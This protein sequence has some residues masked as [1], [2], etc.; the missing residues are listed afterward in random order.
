MGLFHSLQLAFE[1]LILGITIVILV[2]YVSLALL[3]AFSLRQYLRKNS[4]LDYNAILGCPFA[5]PISILAPAYNEGKTIIE[6]V[7]ALLSL[8]YSDFEVIVINDGSRDDTFDKMV[9]E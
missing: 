1:Y 9:T 5:P 2:A 6:N 8:Y 3:S 4:I 7:R